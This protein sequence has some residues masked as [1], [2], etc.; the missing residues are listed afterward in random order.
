MRRGFFRR[1][2]VRTG[3]YSKLIED[4]RNDVTRLEPF[5]A[6]ARIVS[7]LDRKREKSLNYVSGLSSEEQQNTVTRIRENDAIQ[8][9]VRESVHERVE[10]YR[11]ALERMVI[12]APSP[13]AVDAERALTLLQQRAG[14]YGV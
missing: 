12:A 10:S 9:W 8:R 11:V 3:R 4:I 7:D 6:S 13:M 14:A 2:T 5:F 1:L